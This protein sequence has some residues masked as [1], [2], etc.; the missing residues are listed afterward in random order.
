VVINAETIT[1]DNEYEIS[2]RGFLNIMFILKL[3]KHRGITADKEKQLN[4][5]RCSKKRCT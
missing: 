2:K 3:G 4:K 1:I 5:E